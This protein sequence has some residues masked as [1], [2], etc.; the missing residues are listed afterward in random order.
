MVEVGEPAARAVSEVLVAAVPVAVCIS[1][2][3]TSACLATPSLPI[4]PRVDKVGLEARAVGAVW[5]VMAY[6]VIMVATVQK[7]ASL[8]GMEETVETAAQVVTVVTVV[9]GP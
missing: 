3:E 8:K 5:V 7:R 9:T 2:A 1:R 4:A 6:G